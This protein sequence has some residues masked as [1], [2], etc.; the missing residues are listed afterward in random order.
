MYELTV[1]T[2]E[3]SLDPVREILRSR[4]L[5]I[6]SEEAP[7]KLHLYYPI[8]KERYGFLG[9]LKFEGTPEGVANLSADLNLKEG[10][11]RILITR[12]KEIKGGEGEVPVKPTARREPRRTEAPTRPTEAALTNEELE[13]KIEEILK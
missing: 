6:L 10:V 1:V 12:A 11:L 5:E 9:I 2:K 7:K 8:K 4:G 13:K 3:E